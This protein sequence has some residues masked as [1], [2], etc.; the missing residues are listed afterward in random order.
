M[1]SAAHVTIW[2]AAG[3]MVSLVAACATIAPVLEPAAEA[4]EQTPAKPPV[5]PIY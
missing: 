1:R 5:P 3:L 4:L 2:L